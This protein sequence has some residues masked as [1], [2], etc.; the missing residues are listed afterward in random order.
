MGISYDVKVDSFIK[1]IGSDSCVALRGLT[2]KQLCREID[3]VIAQKS[4][5]AGEIQRRLRHME[6]INTEA[7]RRLLQAE[8]G[9]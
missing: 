8:G 6:T 1:D 4:S 2:G 3:R 7:A 9:L 5:R